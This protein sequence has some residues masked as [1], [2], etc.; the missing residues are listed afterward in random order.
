VKRHATNPN[1]LVPLCTGM[2]FQ[3]KSS[4]KL[5]GIAVETVPVYNISAGNPAQFSRQLASAS[6]SGV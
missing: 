3:G 2:V 5:Q 4:A 1:H 6:D